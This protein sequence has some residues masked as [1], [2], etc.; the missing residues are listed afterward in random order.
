MQLYSYILYPYILPILH[1]KGGLK[2]VL[3]P[4]V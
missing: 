3:A 4:R 1:S 2:D